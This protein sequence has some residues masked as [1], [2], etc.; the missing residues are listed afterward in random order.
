MTDHDKN[1]LRQL[2]ERFNARAIE[3]VLVHLAED[4]ILAN[5]QSA[6]KRWPLHR[7]QR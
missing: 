3:D 5:C 1:M 6:R 4:V 2:Y 7:R